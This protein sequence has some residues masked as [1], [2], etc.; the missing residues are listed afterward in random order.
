[1][2]EDFLKGFSDVESNW[3]AGIQ[4]ELRGCCNPETGN[5][6]TKFTGSATVSA[7]TNMSLQIW[8]CLG[9]TRPEVDLEV[10]TGALASVYVQLRIQGG[11]FVE[12]EL[13]S[14]QEMECR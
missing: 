4:A 10:D 9:C 14:R 5:R 1:M 7:K 11:I 3:S 12:G 2:A 6:G 13:S 8:P